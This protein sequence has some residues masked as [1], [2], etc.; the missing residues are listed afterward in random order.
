MPYSRANFNVFVTKV[1]ELRTFLFDLYVLISISSVQT[2]PLE[3]KEKRSGRE[4]GARFSKVPIINGPVKL[5]LFACKIEV[6][7]VLHP[8]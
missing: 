6:S 4:P 1:L 2:P 5:L 7:I 8:T 3:K